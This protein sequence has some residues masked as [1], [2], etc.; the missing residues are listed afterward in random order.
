MTSTQRK[1]IKMKK[2]IKRS[3][4]KVIR[5]V[6]LAPAKL[7]RI[8]VHTVEQAV[9]TC[10]V[11]G[12]LFVVSLLTCLLSPDKINLILSIVTAAVFF[13]LLLLIKLENYQ[14][15]LEEQEFI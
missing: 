10:E 13:G 1:R 14:E 15:I 3:V 5:F 7:P 11:S 8:R 4:K 6:L 12:I 9:K 2:R